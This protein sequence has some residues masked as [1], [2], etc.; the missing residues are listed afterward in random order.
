MI[1]MGIFN[2]IDTFFFISLGITFI[3]ILLLVFHF[4]QRI[5]DVEDKNETMFLIINDIVKELSSVKQNCCNCISAFPLAD[6]KPINFCCA[7]PKNIIR[8]ERI[9]VS[10]EEDH[11]DDEED[12]D[13]DDEEDDDEEDDNDEEDEAPVPPLSIIDDTNLK[14]ISV[15]INETIQL[16][17]Q[18]DE[19]IEPVNLHVE[20]IEGELEPV[21]VEPVIDTSKEIYR[22]MTL[23]G[24]KALVITKGLLTDPSKM[25]K[26]ELLKLLEA[27]E[28]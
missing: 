20:K 28:E 11:D 18:E 16:V 10:D 8:Q 3:L 22:K 12:D 27:N 21:Y 2:Y 14:I 4:K 24:L 1:L 6:N 23:Q 7:P 15:D 25:K 13:D 26:N 19:N 17:E 9:I 5:S